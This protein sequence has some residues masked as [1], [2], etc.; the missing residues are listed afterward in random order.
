MT[1]YTV[2]I[3]PGTVMNFW[4]PL[5]TLKKP[6]KGEKP[7]PPAKPNKPVVVLVHAFA[8][9]GIVM[10]QFQ[11]GAL[12]KKYSVYVPDL[13]FS[14]G[15]ITDQT[16]RS[17]SFQAE[18]LATGLRKLRVERCTVVGLSYGGM[19]GFKMA[20]LYPDLVK[21]MVVSCSTIA[22]T[23]SIRETILQNLG[24]SSFSELLLPTS[25]KGLKTLLSVTAHKKLWFPDRLFK[26]F[27]EVCLHRY[28]YS[29]Y[30]YIYSMQFRYILHN[31]IIYISGNHILFLWMLYL[32]NSH[33]HQ[34]AFC[35]GQLRC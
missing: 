20:E 13:L 29:I 22:M 31:C 3:E 24:F 12:T 9:E 28:Y 35:V 8:A 5:E 32:A 26:D 18:C 30:I 4:I 21:A 17:P 10:W 15:S 23:E 1:P 25:V 14:G 6:K 7:E 27:L 2:E 11:V 19:V 33:P 16:D 34:H